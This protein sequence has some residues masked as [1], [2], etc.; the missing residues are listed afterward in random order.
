MVPITA[1][2][3]VVLFLLQRFGTAAVGR[4]FGPVMLLWFAV[5]GVCGVNGIAKHPAILKALS[6]TYALSF[7]FNT[8]RPRSSRSRRSSSP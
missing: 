2:I 1:V 6:P 7:F 8:S 5:I 3:I 4:L